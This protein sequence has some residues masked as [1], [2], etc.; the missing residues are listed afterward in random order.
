MGDVEDA[1]GASSQRCQCSCS[2][3]GETDDT[4]DAA[5]DVGFL[6]FG[7]QE[8]RLDVEVNIESGVHIKQQGDDPAKKLVE[9]IQRFVG[10]AC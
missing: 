4:E 8:V 1:I 7:S 2:D 3:R 10:A 9:C 5:E 6:K